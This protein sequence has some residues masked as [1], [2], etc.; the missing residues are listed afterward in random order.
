MANFCNCPVCGHPMEDVPCEICEVCDWERD[1]YQEEC[2]DVACAPNH[3]SL[4]AARAAWA[5]NHKVNI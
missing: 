3:I 1:W 4:N 5:S 2:P